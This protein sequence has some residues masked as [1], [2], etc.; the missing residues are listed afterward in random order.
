MSGATGFILTTVL[1]W[2]AFLFGVFGCVP[3]SIRVC[4]TKDTQSISLSMYIIYCVGCVL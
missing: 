4:K 1:G 3:Q 2:I